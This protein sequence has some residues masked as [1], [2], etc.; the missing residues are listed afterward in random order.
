[1]FKRWYDKIVKINRSL[2][3]RITL[4]KAFCLIAFFLITIQ[5]Y[6]VQVTNSQVYID[7]LGADSTA[8]LQRNMPRGIITDRNS[9]VLVGN[10]AVNIITFQPTP[11]MPTQEVWDIAE[12]LAELIEMDIEGLTARELK[13]LFITVYPDEARALMTDD[14]FKDLEDKDYYQLQ[15]ERIEDHH[16]ERLT[17]KH[18]ITQAIFLN[19]NQGTNL[20]ANTVK[21]NASTEEI[22]VVSENLARLPGVD[23]GVDWERIYPSDI[24]NSQ[25][26]GQITSHEGGLPASDLDYFRALGYERNARVGRSQIERNYE[27]LLRGPQSH[28]LVENE[29]TTLLVEGQPGFELALTLDAELQVAVSDL[30]EREL[31]NTR[32]NESTARYLQEAYVVILNPNTGEVLA[33]VGKTIGTDENTGQLVAH[34][35]PLGTFQKAFTVGSSIKSASLLTG[36][37]QGATTLGRVRYDRPLTFI[38]NTTKRSWT[39][40]NNVND[41]RALYDSSNIYFMLQTLE[42]AGIPNFSD[43]MPLGNFDLNVWD[44]YRRS[45][46]NFGLGSSTGIDLLGE[47][48]GMRDPER[49]AAKALDFSIGQADTYTTMQLAQFAATIATNGKRF[50]TQIVRDLYLPSNTQE[51]QQLLQGFTPRLLNVIDA[52]QSYWDQIHEGHRQTLITGTGAAR[53]NNSNNYRLGQYNPAGKT[54]TA[55]ETARDEDGRN[56]RDAS[57]ELIP[58]HNRTFIGYAP[59]NDPEIA[60]A[61]IV[62]QNETVSV[63]QS[64]PMSLNISREA[65]QAYFDIQEARNQD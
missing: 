27:D 2:V 52:D 35:T 17:E 18:K 49:T 33:M 64:S 16:L 44:T 34:D 30:V 36:Y 60:I 42:M 3:F 4:L 46:A 54:G 41:I 59:I 19:M 6:Q 61:V 14:E 7:F 5:L 39:Q 65:M 29:N 62:P 28:Y 50:A 58:V 22:A 56:L 53:F 26:F 8:N 10:E 38:D 24:G 1:M 43:R 25:I 45:F 21:N 9:Q 40:L 31:L 12:T 37:Q 13:D 23:V 47:S 20:L 32:R 48:I 15:L 63:N 51:E 57:G 11:N 55:Q